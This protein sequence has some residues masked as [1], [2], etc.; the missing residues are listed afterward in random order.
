VIIY[1]VTAFEDWVITWAIRVVPP[2][3]LAVILFL[4]MLSLSIHGERQ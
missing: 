1:P 4:V 2:F 3:S